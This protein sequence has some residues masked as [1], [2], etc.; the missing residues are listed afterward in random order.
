VDI[1]AGFQPASS[2]ARQTLAAASEK[3]PLTI[4]PVVYAEIAG[5]FSREDELLESVGALGIAVAEFT[6]D[7]LWQAGLA[8]RSYARGRGPYVECARCGR[9]SNVACPSCE[10][11]QAWRQHLITDFLIGAHAAAQADALFTRDAGYYR[12]YFPR[13]RLMV[14]GAAPPSA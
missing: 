8:W 3:E 9:R 13:L 12:T 5:N 10:A 4:C 11:P 6:P 7:A 2:V 1:L 14:P